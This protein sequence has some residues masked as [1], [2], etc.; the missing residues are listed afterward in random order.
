MM[1]SCRLLFRYWRSNGDKDNALGRGNRSPSKLNHFDR[2]LGTVTGVIQS[3]D[4]CRGLF[5]DAGV[6][7]KRAGNNPVRV[8]SWVCLCGCDPKLM[9]LVPYSTHRLFHNAMW[10]G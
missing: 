3:T 2:K 10:H 4:D 1:K 9:G 8:S 7:R 5:I 6:H